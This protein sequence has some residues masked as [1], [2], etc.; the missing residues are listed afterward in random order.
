[1][2]ASPEGSHPLGLKQ[3]A[4]LLSEY[5][6]SWPALFETECA[7]I[8]AALPDLT[9]KLHHIGSTAV[10][11][12]AAKPILDIAM[13]APVGQHDDIATAL[14][15]LG[16]IDRGM[17]SGWLF[18]RLRDHDIRTHNLHLFDTG[19][20]ELVR[21]L[22]FRDRLREN[23]ALRANYKQLK[24]DLVRRYQ[25]NRAAYAPAK[26]EFIASALGG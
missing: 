13:V 22:T 18:I 23:P 7:G 10:A 5:D 4:L 24:A 6:R 26:S 1:M 21:H 19:D 20:P 11:G 25:G 12:L 2:S 16:Y 17:R 15:G 8:K 9:M 3:G 14:T